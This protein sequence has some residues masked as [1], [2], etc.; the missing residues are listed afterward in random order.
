MSGINWDR[1]RRR[2]Q[3]RIRGTEDWRE[4]EPQGPC[5]RPLPRRLTKEQLRAQAEAA[6]KTWNAQPRAAE[7]PPWD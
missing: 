4:M 2:A 7:P 6:F 1:N 3:I 5:A